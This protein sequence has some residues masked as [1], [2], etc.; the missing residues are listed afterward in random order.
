MNK[1]FT[2]GLILMTLF[3]ISCKEQTDKNSKKEIEKEVK[4]PEIK[5]ETKSDSKKKDAD[6]AFVKQSV[7]AELA[8]KIKN[9]IAKDLLT[10]KDLELIPADQRKFQF[11]QIDMNNDGKKEIFV[12]LISPYFCGSGGCTVLLLNNQLKR[13]TKFTVTRTPLWAEQTIKNGW[14]ILL[15]KSD[16]ELKEMIYKNGTYP[17]NPSVVKKAPYDAASGNAEIMFDPNFS[18]AKTYNF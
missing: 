16:G 9:Y 8:T 1:L 2:A 15:T 5:K 11:Y 12:N 17:S 7:N 3:F 6:A 18:N 13:I 4:Q 10:K 14:R